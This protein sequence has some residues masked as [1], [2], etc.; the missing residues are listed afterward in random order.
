MYKNEKNYWEK[1][2]IDI[3]RQQQI[4]IASVMRNILRYLRLWTLHERKIGRIE[5]F[6]IL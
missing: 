3:L 6:R 5:L 2:S 1:F 4:W